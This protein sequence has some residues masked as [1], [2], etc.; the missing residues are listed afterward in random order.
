MRWVDSGVVEKIF[1]DSSFYDDPEQRYPTIEEQIKMAR[2]VALSLSAPDNVTARG[3]R[4]FM[5]RK[6]K[7]NQWTSDNPSALEGLITLPKRSS[8]GPRPRQRT[9]TPEPHDLYYNPTPWKT[10]TSKKVEKV[11]LDL[12]VKQIDGYPADAQVS[13]TKNRALFERGV[14]HQQSVHTPYYDRTGKKVHASGS[15]APRACHG[16]ANEMK[17]MRGKGAKL[18]AQRRAKL[19]EEEAE[20]E[21]VGHG[22]WHSEGE[23]AQPRERSVEE[24]EGFDFPDPRDQAAVNRLEELISISK[25]YMTPWELTTGRVGPK[26]PWQ[27]TTQ[28]Q[29]SKGVDLPSSTRSTSEQK[30]SESSLPSFLG[31]QN[32]IIVIVVDVIVI[33]IIIII[34]II[35]II[36]VVVVVV[37]VI[38]AG[39]L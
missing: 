18:F 22:G 1:A 19:A 15:L 23:A 13:F 4:M 10:P 11:T 24:R 20:E 38:I 29:P 8:S 16:L 28:V 3:H 9:A 21:E 34:V 12:R 27:P 37:V 14:R 39:R 5:K 31:Q 17:G 2:K 7:A 32:T 6:E 33:I 36:I 30:T 25:A 35:I 26:E